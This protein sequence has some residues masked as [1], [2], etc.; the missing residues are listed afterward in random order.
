MNEVAV[1]AQEPQVVT[2]KKVAKK[3]PKRRPSARARS[4]GRTRS[5]GRSGG[6]ARSSGRTPKKK[7]AFPSI[8]KKVSTEK[9][10]GDTIGPKQPKR[11]A[12]PK[13]GDS[14]DEGLGPKRV[15]EINVV[16]APVE[17]KDAGKRRAMQRQAGVFRSADFLKRENSFVTAVRKRL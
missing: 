10:L 17:T 5:A 9:H 3:A 14:A 13:T 12:K 4:S 11:E 8:I 1:E 2:E 16:A 15:K 6:G 7:W